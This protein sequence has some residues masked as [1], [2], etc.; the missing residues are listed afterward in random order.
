MCLGMP[1]DCLTADATFLV[2][3][4]KNQQQMAPQP[5]ELLD[6][7]IGSKLT[8]IMRDDHEFTGI[9]AGFD[10]FVNLVLTTVSHSTNGISS[11]LESVLLNGSNIAL[12]VPGGAP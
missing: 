12:L 4:F 6:A 1:F 2:F 11:T 8:V 3:P 10:D 9:L 5:L 7:C